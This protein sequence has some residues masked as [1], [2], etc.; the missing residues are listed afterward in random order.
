M[1]RTFIFN[2]LNS[3]QYPINSNNRLSAIKYLGKFIKLSRQT[4]ESSYE[5]GFAL[6]EEIQFQNTYLELESLRFNKSF[7]YNISVDESLDTQDIQV[8]QLL[9]QPFV[10]NAIIHGLLN[11][12]GDNKLVQIHFKKEA[13]FLPCT[14]EDNGIGRQASH[15]FKGMDIQKKSRVM[16]VT[17][18]RIN[19]LF[20][21]AVQQQLLVI[22]DKTDKNGAPNGTKVVLKIPL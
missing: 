8:P 4:L 20:S 11:K 3:I 2:P 7:D 9:I 16:E 10:E 5:N 18:K 17:Q 13:V 19:T 22:F 14:I 15:Q 6:S 1:R 12:D 21:H